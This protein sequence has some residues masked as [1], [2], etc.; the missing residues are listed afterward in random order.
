MHRTSTPKHHTGRTTHSAAAW[1][2]IS[3][4]PRTFK[5]KAESAQPCW[6][7]AA[8]EGDLFH[9][10][11][12]PAFGLNGNWIEHHTKLHFEVYFLVK[13]AKEPVLLSI[14]RCWRVLKARGAFRMERV[15]WSCA[16]MRLCVFCLTL[17]N[18]FHRYI[19]GAIKSPGC[20]RRARRSW[21]QRKCLVNK[22]A[23]KMRENAPK[24]VVTRS[25]LGPIF[26]LEFL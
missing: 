26:L 11:M 8:G 19:R 23:G 18:F 9:P 24:T 5:T 2:F 7:A 21:I 22:P 12:M 10:R 4:P 25:R 17:T 3:Q 6:R 15:E 20:C 16:A 13:Q 14:S 1:T